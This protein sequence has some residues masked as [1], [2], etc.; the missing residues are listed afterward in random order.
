MKIG[1][2]RVSTKDQR[3]DSQ[4]DKLNEA[5]V[6]RIY[7][8]KESGG[9]WDRVE[10]DRC[11][12]ALRE[13]DT[14]VVY[15]L[16]RLARSAKQLYEIADRLSSIGVELVSIKEQIDTSTPMGRAMFGMIG[17]MAELERDMIRERTVA[18][19]EAARARGRKGGRKP[20]DQGKIRKALAL[21]D[22][23][24]YSIAEITK[25]TGVKKA[26]IYKYLKE[27]KESDK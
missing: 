7:Q 2:A 21:Y 20:A 22:S 12:D 4:L 25:E 1:Y 6:E 18:G 9:K 14:L 17:V 3:L 27:R 26:T 13:G 10:L 15:K 23:K 5:G 24:Q 11:L 8:E 19:L 16:D